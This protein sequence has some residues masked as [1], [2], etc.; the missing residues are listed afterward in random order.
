MLQV[1]STPKVLVVAGEIS[2][3][4]MRDD[5]RII[6]QF[7][8]V[9]TLEL[10]RTPAPGGR[11][12]GRAVRYGLNFGL[13]VYR[14]LR[15]NMRAV[16]FWFASPNYS[17]TMAMIAKMLGR[18]VVV[19]TG[20]KDAVYVPDIDWG[21][22]K[23]P[24]SKAKFRR[25]MRFADAV[26]PFS[27][28]AREAIATG[29]SPPHI[30]TAY[31]AI[32]AG[33]FAPTAPVRAPRVVTCCYEYSEQ[34]IVQKGLDHFVEAARRL[35]EIPFVLVG[36][37]VDAAARAFADAMPRNVTVIPRIAGRTG[38]RDFLAASGVYAQL[39]AH[40]GFGVS[41]AESMACGCIPVVS[42][43]YSLPEVVGDAGFVVRY[44]DAEETIRSIRSALKAPPEA[45]ARARCRVT[46]FGREARVEVL[47]DELVRLIP[48]LK[49]PPLRIE[50][51]CGSTGVAGTIGVDARRTVQ[52]RAVCDVR[53][54]CFRSGVADEV[55]SFCVLE[56][57]D[58]PYQLLDEVVRIL[59]PSGRAYLRVPNI[60]TFSSHLDP[61]HRFLAD[62][63]I[64]REI[65]KG[66]F[67]S[68]TVVPEGL[69]YRDNPLLTFINWIL[70]RG[71]RFYELTQGWTFVCERKRAAPL[72]A[73]TGWWQERALDR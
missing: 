51:G 68:V 20:G 40:E 60:G 18:K 9:G 22:L 33:F 10:G 69:K 57:L 7:A 66:Y 63:R 13:F 38:Y 42:D 16:I 5:L 28:S 23:T 24:S 46:R 64:W 1:P 45:R 48:E 52:T 11:V 55:Y 39:S 12:F 58:D 29:Y 27:D 14:L 31:P 34:N 36:N 4:F 56:H 17:P 19:I 6:H 61:T 37:P 2:D 44:G 67:E 62:L 73:Y 65:M 26:L 54:S 21:D 8:D 47:H 43:R 30:R 71:L 72:R 53:F 25:L 41:V 3:S 49:N 70:V 15:Y 59:K 32:D 50:L 35:P